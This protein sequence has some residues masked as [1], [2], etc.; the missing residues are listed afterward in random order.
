MTSSASVSAASRRAEPS[1][2]GSGVHDRRRSRSQD[3]PLPV[4]VLTSAAGVLVCALAYAGARMNAGW[5]DAVSWI[6]LMII[7]LPATFRLLGSTARRSERLVLVGVVA[8]GLYTVFILLSPS[9]F[10]L[11]DELGAYRSVEDILRTGRLYKPPN[12]I[13]AAYSSY[14]G[15]LAV[16]AAL[17]RLT[18]LGVVPCGYVL[19]GVA[20]LLLTG[21][22]F[23]FVERITRSS[24]VAG[25]AVVLYMAN[26]NF[27]FFDSQFAYESLAIGIGAMALWMTS[28][29]AEPVSGTNTDLIVAL[30]LDAALVM[31]HHLTSYAVTLVVIVWATFSQFQRPRTAA[32]QRLLV[33]ALFS[34]I[35]TGAYAL[36]TLKATESDIGGSIVGSLHGLINVISGNEA[37]KHP[38]S[39]ASGYANPPLEQAAGLLSVGL[40]MAALPFGLYAVWR[41]R[42]NGLGLLILELTAL[43]YPASLGLRLTAAGSETSNRTSEFVFAGLATV[44]ALTFIVLFGR[45]ADRRDWAGRLL[46]LLATAYIG[47]AFAGGITVGTAPYDLLPTGYAVGADARSVD[48]EGVQAARWAGRW[49]APRLN[50]FGDLTDGELFTAYS[51][52]RPQSGTI[53]SHKLG[54]LFTSATFGPVQRRIITYDKIRYVVVDKRDSSALPYS[55]SYFGDADPGTYTSPIGLRALTKFD[56]VPCIDRIFSSGNIVVYDTSRL[57]A[58]CR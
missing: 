52:L 38:F 56:F 4:L 48:T 51:Q 58:G 36:A 43:L 2:R 33:L 17:S 18:G 40:L 49:L 21:G 47:V 35:M 42:H 55:G 22:L 5:A 8:V 53:G 29:V 20:K 26:P 41:R 11:H 1:R 10:G 45:V 13:D 44:V 19:V 57:L 6:G 39:S 3:L 50:F 30:M 12:P 46:R 25:I 7:L 15:I 34:V 28:R 32:A 14:P 24:R 31:T 54:E 27:F 9:M 23:L 16:T 37:S